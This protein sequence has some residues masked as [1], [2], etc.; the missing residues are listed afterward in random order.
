M[1]IPYPPS[2][3]IKLARWA[4]ANEIRRSAEGILKGKRYDGSDNWPITWADDGH[5]YTAYGDGHGFEPYLDGK[6]GLGLA[7]I[8]GGPEDFVGVNIR[9]DVENSG[10]GPNGEKASGMLMVEGVIYM[11]LRNAANSR[12]VWSEDY[13]KTW[14]EADWKFTDGWG[15]PTLLNFGQHYAGARDDYVY[16]YSPDHDSAYENGDRFVMGRVAKDKMRDR[17]AYEFL[18]S[19]ADGEP[20]WTSDITQCG[21]VFENVGGCSRSG[22]SYNAGLER[23]LWWHQMRVPDGDNSRFSG[24]FAIYDAP[25]PWGPW[26]TVFYTTMWDVGPGDQAF[27]PTRWMS[28]DGRTCYLVFSGDDTFAVRKVEFDV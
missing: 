10:Y 17:E 14:M 26:T 3:V 9:A 15:C 2:E 18:Q 4:P 24:G 20:V 7:R 1:T 28:E 19:V 16:L 22:I 12:L 27:F 8:E 25:E 11:W 6:L 23:Y 21:A 13:C 5:Q